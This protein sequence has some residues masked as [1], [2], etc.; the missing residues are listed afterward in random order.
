MSRDSSCMN[1][2]EDHDDHS[3]SQTKENDNRESDSIYETDPSKSLMISK[4]ASSD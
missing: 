1:P 4:P 2:D 3:Q